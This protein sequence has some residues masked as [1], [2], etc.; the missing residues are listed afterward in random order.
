MNCFVS[1]IHKLE[2]CHPARHDFEKCIFTLFGAR[3]NRLI[4]FSQSAFWDINIKS[5][6]SISRKPPKKNQIMDVKMFKKHKNTTYIKSMAV[7]CFTLLEF[8]PSRARLSLTFIS[9]K[10]KELPH[11]W[12][13]DLSGNVLHPLWACTCAGRHVCLLHE[14]VCLPSSL[15]YN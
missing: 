7:V 3:I 1:M 10:K 5:S 13:F 2:P 14:C 15:I 8:K 11:V 4:F 6:Q 12:Y 9:K